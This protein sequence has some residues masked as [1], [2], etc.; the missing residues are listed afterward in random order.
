MV[1]FSYKEFMSKNLDYIFCI[2]MYLHKGGI[3][4]KLQLKFNLIC[5]K[6]MCIY[7]LDK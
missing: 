4:K 1:K 2:Y 3:P 6:Y 7:I 5:G